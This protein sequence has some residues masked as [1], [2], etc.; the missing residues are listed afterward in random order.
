M[1]TNLMIIKKIAGILLIIVA[2]MQM[3]DILI[4]LPEQLRY[5]GGFELIRP[6]L[7]WPAQNIAFILLGISL[8]IEKNAPVVPNFESVTD[9]TISNSN[10]MPSAGLNI[11]SFLI[12]IVGVIIY[13]VDKEK[14]PRKANAAIKAA[15]WGVLISIVL[16]LLAAI[17]SA[18]LFSSIF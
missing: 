18:A 5:L 4:S 2:L 7:L 10:D 14:L 15:L 8:L 17:I 11:L 1:F 13:F 12:P 3:M 9:E 16:G 6:L